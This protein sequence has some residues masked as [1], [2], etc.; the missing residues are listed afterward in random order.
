MGNISIAN[1]IMSISLLLIPFSILIVGKRITD[2]LKQQRH[3]F[4]AIE[5][6]LKGLEDIT[7]KKAKEQYSEDKR[8]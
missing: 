2:E 5:A 7:A 3:I 6:R 4:K 8:A 1:L